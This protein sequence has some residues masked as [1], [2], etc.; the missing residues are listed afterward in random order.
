MTNVFSLPAFI[1]SIILAAL[2]PLLMVRF[3]NLKKTALFS[4]F[5]W[6]L[7]F[8]VMGEYF[9]LL[10][11]QAREIANVWFIFAIGYMAVFEYGEWLDYEN[12]NR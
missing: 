1:V 8:S 10:D 4:C 5:T 7:F 2:F 3:F 6:F 11:Y 9:R 12:I